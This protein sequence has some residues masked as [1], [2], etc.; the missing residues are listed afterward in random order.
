[1]SKQEAKQLQVHKQMSLISHDAVFQRWLT[2]EVTH[3]SSF[4]N[5]ND[6]CNKVRLI[7]QIIMVCNASGPLWVC[8]YK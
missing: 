1:M 4:M 3:V 6:I 5:I 7:D 2:L 8:V